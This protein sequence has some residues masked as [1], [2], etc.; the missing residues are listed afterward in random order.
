VMCRAPIASGGRSF[1]SA[2]IAV[3]ARQHQ[4]LLLDLRRAGI[5]ISK[6]SGQ[7]NR[8][9]RSR[10]RR[11]AGSEAARDRWW[12]IEKPR[13]REQS[14]RSHARARLVIPVC[15]SPLLQVWRSAAAQSR[16]RRS[17]V[18]QSVVPVSISWLL[19]QWRGEYLS[20]VPVVLYPDPYAAPFTPPCATSSSVARRVVERRC[21]RYPAAATLKLLQCTFTSLRM[22]LRRWWSRD[23]FALHS[24]LLHPTEFAPLNFIVGR[25][26]RHLKF[27]K[28]R[29]TR[30]RYTVKFKCVLVSML[31]VV[32]SWWDNHLLPHP[33]DRP[34]LFAGKYTAE[35]LMSV[36]RDFDTRNDA[37][38]PKWF[39]CMV[40]CKRIFPSKFMADGG[41]WCLMCDGDMLD[42]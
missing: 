27:L 21:V 2:P 22:V 33:F 31:S 40:G 1:R 3:L 35:Y 28:H 14:V 41:C 32:H 19:S 11:G 38:P 13:R 5:P 8:A 23:L 4:S 37:I 30:V 15:V 26:P 6:G 42:Y 20:H 9:T 10:G 36:S 17:A 12:H 29:Y 7:C 16:V 34:H 25:C 39:Y 24:N 18:L